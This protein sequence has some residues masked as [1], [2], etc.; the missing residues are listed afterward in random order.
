[1]IEQSPIEEYIFWKDF[2]YKRLQINNSV[3]KLL[4]DLLDNAETNMMYYLMEKHHILAPKNN[5][6]SIH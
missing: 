2:I 3:P 1:M 6:S 4:Y 5:N